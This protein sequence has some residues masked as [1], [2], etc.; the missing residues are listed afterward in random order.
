[1]TGGGATG[2]G[3]RT[4]AGAT[5]SGGAT[6]C[7]ATGGGVGGATIAGATVAGRGAVGIETVGAL[8]VAEMLMRIGADCFGGAGD[9]AAGAV[10]TGL[11]DGGGGA[12]SFAGARPV[13]NGATV[14]PNSWRTRSLNRAE[15][16]TPQL[17]HA[18][19]TGLRNISG[20]ASMAYFAPQS[21]I[22]FITV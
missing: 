8:G 4:G 2:D 21:Q 11:A 5:V 17:G 15:R 16:S 7:G 18:K 6:T 20:D 3:I 9:G 10:T 19:L 22:T 14:D 13:C 1:M 12:I